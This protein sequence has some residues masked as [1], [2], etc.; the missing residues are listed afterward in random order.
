MA[1]DNLKNLAIEAVLKCDTV[2]RHLL[3]IP[4]SCFDTLILDVL[5]NMGRQQDL[6]RLS[7]ALS[8][9][10]T[11]KRLLKVGEKRTS[12]HQMLAAICN[13]HV[14]ASELPDKLAKAFFFE[15]DTLIKQNNGQNLT[16]SIG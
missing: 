15:V 1:I 12:L 11:F 14:T 16:V 6:D 10:S 2:Y 13:T 9:F 3:I 7:A 4:G 5:H 8:S